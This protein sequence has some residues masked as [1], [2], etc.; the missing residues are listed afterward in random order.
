VSLLT[1]QEIYLLLNA[2]IINIFLFVRDD[3]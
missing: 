2:D 1:E 3:E